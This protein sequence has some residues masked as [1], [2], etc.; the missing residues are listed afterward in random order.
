MF[1]LLKPIS[2]STV[3]LPNNN[4]IH[5]HHYGEVKVNYDIVLHEVLFV[6]NFKFNLSI[7]ALTEHDNIVVTFTNSGF[8]MYDLLKK[9]MIGKGNRVEDLY[10]LA[11]D[12]AETNAKINMVSART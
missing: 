4:V 7:S 5:V 12:H 2:R 8:T 11:H 10:I 1:I 3:T 6:L 9:K